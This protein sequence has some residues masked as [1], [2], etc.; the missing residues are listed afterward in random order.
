RPGH[1]TI[2]TDYFFN[3][4]PEYLKSSDLERTYT[5][6]ITK[7]KAARYKIVRIEYMVPT[8][9]STIKHTF[10]KDAAK[11]IKHWSKRHKLW[12]RSKINKFSKHN[13]YSTQK[14]L[15][16]KSVRVKKLYGY[17]HLE[18]VVVKRADRQ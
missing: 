8:L 7:T 6:S 3:N 16:V 10:D 11:E 4:D 9:W 17:G 12:Y 1:L 14:F 5:T 15:G 18:E 2:A 13:V